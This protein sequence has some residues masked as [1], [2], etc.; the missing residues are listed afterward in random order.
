MYYVAVHR[1]EVC[2]CTPK[3]VEGDV[4][5]FVNAKVSKSDRAPGGNGVQVIFGANN[6]IC[7]ADVAV[8]N[9]VV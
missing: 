9:A 5:V 3:A 8:N 4:K 7:R 6:A 1:V 2:S